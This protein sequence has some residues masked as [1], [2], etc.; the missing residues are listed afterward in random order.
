MV[1]TE[2][3]WSVNS[4]GSKDD[5]RPDPVAAAAN[6][7]RDAQAPARGETSVGVTLVIGAVLVLA[8][9]AFVALPFF[10]L[11][12][13][14]AGGEGG[15]QSRR[16]IESRKVEAYAAIKDAE[17]DYRMG[18]L[19]EVDFQIVREKYA[20]EAMAALAALDTGTAEE[21]GGAAAAT[22][23]AFCPQCGTG[24]ARDARYCGSCGESLT[25]GV[26]G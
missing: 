11:A 19:T 23:V 5:L 14:A 18:K 17:L 25:P 8:A 4:G 6:R 7:E 24:T 20:R 3:C 1:H 22:A 10:G 13:S 26:D 16:A 2:R 21:G 9:V 12:E 15:D